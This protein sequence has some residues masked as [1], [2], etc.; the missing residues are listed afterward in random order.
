MVSFKTKLVGIIFAIILKKNNNN[1][2][3]IFLFPRKRLIQA[4]RLFASHTEDYLKFE[5]FSQKKIA[6]D[7][8]FESERENINL[9][10]EFLE[11]P[12]TGDKDS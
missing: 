3:T 8:I 11:E 1:F 2:G 9:F 10:V 12:P 4:S 7:F 5:Y 6:K